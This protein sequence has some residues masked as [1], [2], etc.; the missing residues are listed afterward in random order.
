MKLHLLSISRIFFLL[1]LLILCQ[2]CKEEEENTNFETPSIDVSSF[3]LQSTD[4][5]FIKLNINLGSG[6][7]I[8]KAFLQLYDLSAPNADPIQIPVELNNER[9]QQ[10]E[11]TII[12]P[13]TAHD[14]LMRA[15]LETKKNTFITPTQTIYFSA[16]THSFEIG[17]PYIFNTTS[18]PGFP[19]LENGVRIIPHPGEYFLII[20]GVD[21]NTRYKTLDIKLNKKISLKHDNNI[22]YG[23]IGAYIPDEIAPGDYTVTL[24]MDEEEF[25]VEG[26]IRILP[27]K[28]RTLSKIAPISFYS[29]N[30]WFHI[31][32]ENYIIQNADMSDSSISYSI[33]SYN[34]NEQK[35]KTKQEWTL[36]RNQTPTIAVSCHN[37]GYCIVNETDEGISSYNSRGIVYHYQADIEKWE[38]E[39]IYPGKGNRDYVLFSIGKYIYMG[40]GMKINKLDIGNYTEVAQQDF[41]RYD[42]EK[43]RW[44]ELAGV[45]F[46]CRQF[47][48]VNSTCSDEQTAYLFLMDRTLWSYHSE[49]DCWVQEESLRSGSFE[50]FNSSIILYDGKVCLIGSEQDYQKW[51]PDVQLYDP[52]TRQWHLMAIYNFKSYMG[53]PFTPPIHIHNGHIF[54]GPLESIANTPYYK[55]DPCFIEITPQEL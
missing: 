5:C 12:A 37:E 21:W 2:A 19:F 4:R 41:W 45:P 6:F 26:I 55:V 25:E 32:S 30:A 13:Q 47:R 27:W 9:I 7:N 28:T 1:A 3:V 16:L 29:I 14:Y 53:T 46:E 17:K 42:T 44:E 10:P 54:V 23:T 40:A 38:Q 50:R 24:Y 33:C 36:P 43:K 31:N 15:C 51:M 18:D 11:L 52:A 49:N 22:D 34:F 20:T 48:C 35:W 8:K 39:T